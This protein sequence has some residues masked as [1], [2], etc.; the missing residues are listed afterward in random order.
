[1]YAGSTQMQPA[2]SQLATK[3]QPTDIK[4]YI[5]RVF[6]TERINNH[7]ESVISSVG[8]ASRSKMQDSITE[9]GRKQ[10]IR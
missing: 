3:I 7:N 6:F 5:N 1:M 9:F 10:N 4:R 2:C 8:M